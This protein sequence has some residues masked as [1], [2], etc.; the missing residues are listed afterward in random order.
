[1]V[2]GHG[3]AS[4]VDAVNVEIDV[5]V[6]NRSAADIAMESTRERLI[7]A[8][9]QLLDRGG[10]AAVTL[11]DVGRAAGVSHNAPYRHFADK[12]ALLAAVAAREL[13]RQGANLN[14]LGD[15]IADVQAVLQ[16]Y[17]R[18]ALRYPERFRLTFGRWER[19]DAELGDA[20]VEARRALTRA[21][22]AAQ[23]RGELPRADPE[24]LGSLLLALAHGSADMALAGHLSATG[25]GAADAEDLVADLFA[26]LG[27]SVR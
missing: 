5:D 14:Q 19:E 22:A 16:G 13:G 6:V 11:R 17:V 4:H 21:V 1:M 20:A 24:R 2:I 18:W 25:K 7:A 26:Y 12:D 23:A 8:A 15:S 27:A 10:P 3:S 9:A